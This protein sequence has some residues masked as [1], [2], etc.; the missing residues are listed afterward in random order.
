LSKQWVCLNSA[1]LLKEALKSA[2]KLPSQQLHKK[3]DSEDTVPYPGDMR[4]NIEDIAAST[5]A[6]LTL[7]KGGKSRQA[8]MQRRV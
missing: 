7:E 6:P 5:T 1:S 8:A 2:C 4:W 3:I